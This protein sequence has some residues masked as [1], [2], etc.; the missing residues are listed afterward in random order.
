[1]ILESWPWKQRLLNDADLIERWARK[2]PT[3]RRSFMIE[4][5]V[6]LAAYAMRKLSEARK[7][8]SSF[9]E[10][11]IKCQIYAACKEPITIADNHKIDEVYDLDNPKR[12]TI[13]AKSLLDLIIHS[14]IFAEVVDDEI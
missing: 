11:V 10:R 13:A 6:F 2:G 12:R 5:K 14:F 9:S 8:S 1:M 4:Q 3:E 7:L